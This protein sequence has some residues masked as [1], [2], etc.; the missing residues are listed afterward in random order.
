MDMTS[1][2][3]EEEAK[4]EYF[5]ACRLI[6]LAEGKTME[7]IYLGLSMLKH[8]RVDDC[9]NPDAYA[10]LVRK[11][12]KNVKRVRKFMREEAKVH[13]ARNRELTKRARLAEESEG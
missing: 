2:Q 7:N 10:A 9:D 12:T 5:Q 13:F 4:K 8:L 3:L 11:I 1:E 6:R